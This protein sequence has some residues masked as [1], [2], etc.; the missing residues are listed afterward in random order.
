M[1]G[2]RALVIMRSAWIVL[3]ALIALRAITASAAEVL[4][5]LYRGEAIITGQDNLE[6]RQR[7]F[8]ESLTD[9]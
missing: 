1:S 3:G 2:G 4:P 7:G 5:D 9:V 8:R 6:E